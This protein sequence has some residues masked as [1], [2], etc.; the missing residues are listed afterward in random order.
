MDKDI[1]RSNRTNISCHYKHICRLIVSSFTVNLLPLSELITST[2]Y[3]VMPGGRPI[4][5][6]V[7]KA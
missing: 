7:Q 1:K 5:F 6:K 4:S 2:I 3:D